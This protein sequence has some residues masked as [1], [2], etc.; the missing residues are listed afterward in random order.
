MAYDEHQHRALHEN[1]DPYC[2]DTPDP[3]YATGW[4]QCY[5]L[6]DIREIV[7]DNRTNPV[8]PLTTWRTA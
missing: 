5:R 8:A 4:I 1:V 3:S 2:N 7:H 6:P